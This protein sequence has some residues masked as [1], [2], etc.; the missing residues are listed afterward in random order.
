MASPNSSRSLTESIQ[1]TDR[2]LLNKELLVSILKAI[3]IRFLPLQAQQE[4]V[5]A[6]IEAVR[7]VGLDRI[8]EVLTPAIQQI[9][10]V[11]TKGFLVA[12][13]ETP[14]TMGLG[15]IVTF[16]IQDEAQ[17]ALFTPAPYSIATRTGSPDDYGV[18][19]TVSYNN[20]TGAF[21]AEFISVEGD[22]GPHDD[23]FIGAVAGNVLA[24]LTHLGQVITL[25]AEAL[26]YRNAAASSASTA[27]NR[28]SDVQGER[29]SFL[30]EGYGIIED[31]EEQAL[32]A[33]SS[34]L[35]AAGSASTAST[36]AGEAASSAAAAQ[37]ALE[38][39]SRVILT[40]AEYNALATKDD[41]T[42][43]YIVG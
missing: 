34:A 32:A 7:K 11:Q 38:A 5:T 2:T 33:A 17:R 41:T 36:K 40:L 26:G 16:F 22:P 8:N 37:D 20:E 42:F 13:S 30:L 35:A 21:I 23:W 1:L 19:R 43:Y 31:A 4:A 9:M 27:A 39:T 6:A 3:D 18:I 14:I 24:S 29:T 10:E 25:H 28:L 12:N 15:D